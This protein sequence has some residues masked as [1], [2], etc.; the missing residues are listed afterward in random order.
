VK[1]PTRAAREVLC[2]GRCDQGAP[3]A[4]ACGGQLTPA[5]RDDRPLRAW[6]RLRLRREA[7][8]VIG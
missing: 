7:G 4:Q 3:G 5:R 2:G 8:E 6:R 1:H